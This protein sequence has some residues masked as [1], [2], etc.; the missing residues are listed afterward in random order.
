MKNFI[1]LANFEFNRMSK[2]LF[3][4]MGFVLVV[5][6]GAVF[7]ETSTF[8]SK[9]NQYMENEQLTREQALM[10]FDT[11]SFG[12]VM[13]NILFF[14][15]IFICVGAILFY[16]FLIWYRDW[17]GKNTFVYRLLMLP[18]ERFNIFLSKLTTVLMATFGLVAFQLVAILIERS[19]FNLLIPDDLRQEVYFNQ[20]MNTYPFTRILLPTNFDEFL[21]FY[22]TGIL[23]VVVIFTVILLERSFRI[24]GIALGILYGLAM[25][26]L[27][28]SPIII[29]EEWFLDHYFYLSEIFWIEVVVSLIALALSMII[30]RKLLNDKVRV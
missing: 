15:P 3:A 13:G 12:A 27:V 1:K 26:G 20:L 11:I 9:F 21:I 22:G 30:S 7:Y 29:N 6:L 2:L 23:S 24:K 10:N 25:V 18:T 4:L 17:L 19:V 14:G 8:M 16:I 5:Q 28:L